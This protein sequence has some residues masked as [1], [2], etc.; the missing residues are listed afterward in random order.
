MTVATD[1][2]VHFGSASEYV[3]LELPG[4]LAQTQAGFTRAEIMLPQFRGEIRPWVDFECLQ[5][6][7]ASLRSLYSDLTGSAEL[8][9][10]DRQLL[11]H[12]QTQPG[13]H[14]HLRGEAWE[15]A[16]FGSC[17]SFELKLD[18][19]FLLA[20]LQTLETLLKR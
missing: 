5:A 16:T 1:L 3:R 19:S 8:Q 20:P 2:A 9:P 13:G 7:A 6:F 4:S 11:L 17:L 12:F 10:R 15:K 14:V 18:Q